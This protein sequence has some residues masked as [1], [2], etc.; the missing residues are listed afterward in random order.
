M[1]DILMFNFSQCA[2][3]SAFEH[4]RDRDC[5]Y[6]TK[7]NLGSLMFADMLHEQ[8]SGIAYALANNTHSESVCLH[9]ICSYQLLLL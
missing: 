1:H 9:E 8:A 4:I 7:K 2:K 5:E 3:T 6:E